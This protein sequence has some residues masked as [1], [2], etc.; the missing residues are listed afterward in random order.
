VAQYSNKVHT[1]LFYSFIFNAEN[2][3]KADRNAEKYTSA[4]SVVSA[5]SALKNKKWRQVSHSHIFRNFPLG[6][7]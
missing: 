5:P 6:K 3:K 2:A 1:N 4:L 7:F